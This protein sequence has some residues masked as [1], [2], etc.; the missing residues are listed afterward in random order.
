[1]RLL[2]AVALGLCITFTGTSLAQQ[3]GGVK[4]APGD[5]KADEKHG[6]AVTAATAKSPLDFTMK[7]IDDKDVALSK[8]RGKV[9]LLVNVASKC[10]LTPQYEQ[11]EALHEKYSSKG[12]VIVGYR[13]FWE[14][15][16]RNER[17]HQAVLQ[18][19]VP[20]RL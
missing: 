7:D 12:L 14:P 16:A 4:P 2:S 1:M 5:T 6:A 15:G 8:Y 20:R 18:G 3:T 17:G 13:Q 10:G 19:Q 9:V 11:L